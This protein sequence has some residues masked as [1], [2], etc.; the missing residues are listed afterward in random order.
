MA[1]TVNVRIQ[2]RTDHADCGLFPWQL[3]AKF[4]NLPKNKDLLRQRMQGGN[5]GKRQ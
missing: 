4:G 5:N 2:T 3:K 1:T